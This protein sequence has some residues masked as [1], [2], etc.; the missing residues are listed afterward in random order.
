MRLE[1]SGR[2]HVGLVREKNEDSLLL[3]P[4]LGLYVV[5]DGMGGHVGGQVASQLAVRTI[6]QVVRTG[7]PAQP[8]EDRD[9][10]VTAIRCANYAIYT[11]AR[12]DPSLHNMGTTVVAVRQQ[13]DVLNICHVGDSRI[14]R[15]AYHSGDLEQVTRDHSLVNLYEDNPE[16]AKRYGPPND[17]VIVRAVGLHENVEVEYQ[18][19]PLRP[20]DVYLLCC[21]GLTDMVDDW[22]LREV[23]SDAATA[24]NL[25]EACDALIRAALSFGGIDNTTAILLRVLP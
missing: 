20:G 23:M 10:L 8:P 22:I 9:V 7:Q 14:Y 21:D 2:T 6:D 19:A 4:E 15:L 13:G 25:D 12:Q 3:A 1:L 24:Q 17:N 16:L 11:Q 18:S 5:C